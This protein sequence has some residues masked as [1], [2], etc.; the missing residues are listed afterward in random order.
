MLSFRRFGS[1]YAQSQILRKYPIGGILHGYEIRRV[2]PVPE[3]KLIAVDLKHE[4]TGAEHLHVDRDDKNNVFSIGFKTNPPDSTGVPHILEHTTLCGSVKY[5]VRDPFFK[6]LNR[7]L[8]NFMNAMTAHDYTFFPFATTNQNDFKNL[9]DVYI[10]A[11]LRPLLKAE[12]FFQEGWRLENKDLTDPKSDLQFK[13]VVY[14][15]MKGQI[16]NANYYFWTK[17]QESL[18][19]SLNNSGGDPTKITNLR[20]EDLVEFHEKNYHPSNSKTFTYGN[21]PLIDSLKYLNSELKGYGKRS[22]KTPALLPID[23]KENISVPEVG[24][25]DPMLPPEKQLTSSLTWVC[26]DPHDTYEVFLLGVLGNLLLDGHSSPFYKNL[27][28]SGIGTDFSVNT[29]METTTAKNFFTVGVQGLENIDRFKNA[30]KDTFKMIIDTPFDDKKVDAIIQQIELSKK[31][32]KVDFGLQILYSILP[33]WM[34]SRD[35]FANLSIDNIL[36]RF[37]EEWSS[38]GDALFKNLLKKYLID[39]PSFEFTM[40]GVPNFTDMLEKEESERLLRKTANLNEQDKKVIFERGLLLQ[41]KQ[42]EKQDLS[43]LPSLSVDDISRNGDDFALAKDSTMYTR[44]TDTNGLTYVRGK[45]NLK[46]VISKDLYPYLSL[47]ADSLTHL[48]TSTEDYSEIENEI[49]LFTGG[50]SASIDVVSNP[51]DM[52]PELFFKFNG[53]SLNS[54]VEHI[55]DLWSKVLLNTDFKKHSNKLKVLIKS[56]VSSNTSSIAESGHSYAKLYSSAQIRAKNSIEECFGGIEQVNFMNKLNS[57]IDDDALLQTEVIDKLIEIQKL[58]IT[59]NKLEFLITTDTNEQIDS[60][61]KLLKSFA[62]NFPTFGEK[63]VNGIEG[64]NFPL[65]KS[66]SPMSNTLIKFPFQVHYTSKALPGVSYNNKDGAS[67]Q[68]LANMLT[69]KHLHKE[70]REKGGAYGGG[71]TYNALDGVFSYYS[72]RDPNPLQSLETFDNCPQYILQD[73]KW[74]INDI[75]EAKLTIFQQVDAP[76]P[77]KN[78]GVSLFNS[79]VTDAMRQKRREALLDVKLSDVYAAAEKYLVNSNTKS[80]VIGP[81][82]DDKITDPT[83]EIK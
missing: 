46:N 27:I 31:D 14:N 9:R 50:I 61:K 47:F 67:L 15:E 56:T 78:E 13:G 57:L 29:G 73:S 20:Y 39:T 63:S 24:Q 48:G 49:K 74:T 16:S 4:V 33:G 41:E 44:L 76:M 23:I 17:F 5:P 12:D 58:V 35:P 34:N 59:S 83:W 1:T 21:F 3:L 26:G 45:I 77:R 37:K 51:V 43:C 81:L 25:M 54:K 11:T 62:G 80:T 75:N 52:S 19:P 32:Q 18:Y 6:M 2:L 30:V 72:Y 40:K 7:S 42:N 22:N 71:S 36:N 53:W 69:Y 38:Q 55:T 70:V 68:V 64:K 79:G 82:I 60:V 65:L 66:T 10:D 28:E 8:S